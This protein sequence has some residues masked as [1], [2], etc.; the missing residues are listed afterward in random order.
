MSVTINELSPKFMLRK[1]TC[2]REHSPFFRRCL[3]GPVLD[4]VSVALKDPTAAIFARTSKLFEQKDRRYGHARSPLGQKS[5]RVFPLS[6]LP[7][8]PVLVS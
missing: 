3:A 5:S 6:L 1:E 8:R 7:W 4:S 2:H